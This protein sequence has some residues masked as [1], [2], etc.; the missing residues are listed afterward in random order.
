MFVVIVVVMMIIIIMMVIVMMM[1]MMMMMTMV[2][3]V[4]VVVVVP[5]IRQEGDCSQ[6]ADMCTAG[7][8]CVDGTC[9][10]GAK[11]RPNSQSSLTCGEY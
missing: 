3:V 11:F 6:S 5:G 4:V 1:M 7:S 8:S 9:R 10:C 2:V